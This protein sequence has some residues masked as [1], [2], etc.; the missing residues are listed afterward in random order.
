MRVVWVTL[1]SVARVLS[2]V[3]VAVA[4]KS[5]LLCWAGRSGGSSIVAGVVRVVVVTVSVVKGGGGKGRAH[6]ST[7][8]GDACRLDEERDEEGK[9]A[10]MAMIGI[11]GT[12]RRAWH[13]TPGHGLR[14]SK[15]RPG[16]DVT[17]GVRMHVGGLG[18][19]REA[20]VGVCVV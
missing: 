19:V 15:V 13:R 20:I 11:H 18:L 16:G 3:V 2:M 6:R 1:R 4:I 5:V 8:G 17:V 14:A 12:V 10:R 7:S 9:H